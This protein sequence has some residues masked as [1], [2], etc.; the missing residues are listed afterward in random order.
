MSIRIPEIHP[1][2]D[3]ARDA[4]GLVERVRRAQEPIVITQRGRE[5]AV[6]VPVEL[7]RKMEGLITHKMV[8]P[9]LVNPEDAARFHMEMTAADE[10]P[11]EKPDEMRDRP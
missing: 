4:R 1:I 11:A 10:K 9:R 5:V 2:S 3:L 7:Y 6:L 8:S